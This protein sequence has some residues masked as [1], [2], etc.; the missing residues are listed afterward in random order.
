MAH[1]ELPW[2]AIRVAST[3]GDRPDG[4]LVAIFLDA[5]RRA[6]LV[7]PV[8][9][10]TTTIDELFLRHLEAMVADLAVPAVAFAVVRRTGIPTR[11]D[12]ILWRELSARLRSSPTELVDVAILG[13]DRCWSS[14]TRRSRALAAGHARPVE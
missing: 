5:H 6:L 10:G 14:A 7:T 3:T 8:D 9:E 12:R 13:E 2:D 4:A 1:T 11:R